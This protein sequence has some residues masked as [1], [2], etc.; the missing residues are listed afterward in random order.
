MRKEHL[1]GTALA[2]ALIAAPGVALAQNGNNN[3]PA[4]YNNGGSGSNFN[5]GSNRNEN[6]NWNGNANNFRLQNQVPRESEMI[7]GNIGSG[8]YSG[9]PMPIPTNNNNN[10]A[11]NNNNGGWFGNNGNNGNNNASNMRPSQ[12]NPLLAD[13]GDARASKVVGTT[14]FNRNSQNLGNVNDV[15]IG[16]NGV[17]AIIA[18]NNKKVAVPFRDLIFGDS[19]VK[20][21]DKLVLPNV[22]QAQLN[23]LPVFHYNV[24]NYPNNGNGWLANSNRVNGRFHRGNGYA[25]NGGNGYRNQ[26]GPGLFGNNYNYNGNAGSTGNNNGNNG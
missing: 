15:L 14:V 18:T 13:N 7:Y 20:G 22:T 24:T 4:Y 1:I 25:F 26:G 9:M 23:T 11:G 19:N 10:N 6:Q 12:R 3:S 16:R 5:A 21:N 8:G 17:W 2:A